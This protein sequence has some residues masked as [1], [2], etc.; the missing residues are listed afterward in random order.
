VGYG[1]H[2]G[3]GVG[4]LPADTSQFSL[5]GF[6]LKSLNQLGKLHGSVQ[7]RLQQPKLAFP[8]TRFKLFHELLSLI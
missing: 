2:L 5:G 6:Q 3:L 1:L 4:Q 7:G 8:L